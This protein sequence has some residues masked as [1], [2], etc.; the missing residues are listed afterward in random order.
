MN[1]CNRFLSRTCIENSFA[2]ATGTVKTPPLEELFKGTHGTDYNERMGRFTEP[3]VLISRQPGNDGSK[4]IEMA[5]AAAADLA[6][7]EE[8]PE[9]MRAD[10]LNLLTSYFITH[11]VHSTSQAC[12]E[13]FLKEWSKNR[14]VS[15]EFR[16]VHTCLADYRYKYM[17]IF[18][19]FLAGHTFPIHMRRY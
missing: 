4:R 2:N 16:Y 7:A 12:M 1:A 6:M 5:H 18:G 17:Y 8:I 14:Q 9:S 11:C 19:Y 15:E 10:M 3:E 13:K